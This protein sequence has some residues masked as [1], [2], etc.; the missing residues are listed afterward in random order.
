VP[1]VVLIVGSPSGRREIN[2]LSRNMLS[3][4]DPAGLGGARALSGL[5]IGLGFNVRRPG[6]IRLLGAATSKLLS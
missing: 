5:L 3:Y 1:G 2:L 4:L 6:E